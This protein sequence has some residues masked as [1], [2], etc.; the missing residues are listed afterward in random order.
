MEVAFDVGDGGIIPVSPVEKNAKLLPTTVAFPAP[1]VAIGMPVG[2]IKAPVPVAVW[3]TV[4]KKVVNSPLPSV[5]DAGTKV[6]GLSPPPAAVMIWVEVPEMI[7]VVAPL[8]IVVITTS[9]AVTGW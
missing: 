7:V 4:E 9:T 8:M 2:G 1:P 3:F 5:V 6:G